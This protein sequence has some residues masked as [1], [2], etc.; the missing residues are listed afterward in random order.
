[1]N[2][3]SKNKLAI[4]GILAGAIGGYLYYHFVGCITGT[5][6]I[7]SKPFNST[8]YGA[9][10]GGLLFSIFKKEKINSEEHKN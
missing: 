7:T 3:I 4:I 2:F 10:M 9:V 6:P 5:C 1:M 8:V